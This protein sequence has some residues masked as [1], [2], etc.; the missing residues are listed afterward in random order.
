ME[1]GRYTRMFMKVMGNKLP[2]KWL[3][4]FLLGGVIAILVIVLAPRLRVNGAEMGGHSVHLPFILSSFSNSTVSE[5]IVF[6]S[7]QIPS[8]GSVYWNVPNGMAGVGPYSRFQVAAPGK[9]QI[10]QP[11]GVVRTLIDGE[12]PGPAPFD[13]IDVNAPDVSYDGTK[14]L[15]AGFSASA[16]EAADTMPN[17]TAGGW[18]IYSIHVDGTNLR[19]ITTTDLDYS[20]LDMS[21]FGAAA[22]LFTEYDDTDPV[23]LPDGRFVF[24]STRW[25]SIAQ[26]SGVRTTNLY[27]ANADGSEMRR[28]TSERN[29]AERPLID[30]LTGKIVYS[31]WWRNYRFATNNLNTLPHPDG[32]YAQR[33]GLTIQR[34][35]LGG[36]DNLWTNFWH[37]VAINPDGTDLAL[38]NGRFRGEHDNHYYGGAFT[39]D[40]Q[41]IANFFPMANMSEASGFGGL[42]LLTRGASLYTPLQ[43]ITDLRGN[44]VNSAPPSY[45]IYRGTYAAEPDVLAD[46]RIVFSRALNV[47]QDYGLYLMEADG[48]NPRRLY[49]A[50]GTAELRPRVIQQRPLPPIL[51]DTITQIPGPLPP[52]ANG[53]YDQD[54]TFIF[55]NFNVYFNAPVDSEIVN[56]PAIGSAD[57]IRFFIDH[58]RANRGS[59]PN[60][61]WPIL[62][63]ELPINP[64][65]SLIQ[66]NAP[67][68]VP[69]FEQIRAANGAVPLTNGPLG[70]NGAAHVTGMNFG[71][72]GE[73]VTC[74]GCHAGHSLIPVPASAEDALWTNLAPGAEIAVSSTRNPNYNRGVVDRQVLTGPIYHYWTS[75]FGQTEGQWVELTFPVPVVVRTVRLYNPRYGD[76]ANASLTVNGVT[77][78]LY[79]DPNGL[80]EV[81]S[82]SAGQLSV[83]GTDLPFDDI[84]AQVIR[85]EINNVTGTFYAAVAAGLAEIEVIARRAP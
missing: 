12:N 22:S 61:D 83:S 66:P 23:W 16:F 31:R 32:G 81:A 43:G 65:G 9:L 52:P 76:E 25:P 55:E 77:V 82:S 40:G 6:V 38:W 53:P 68:N 54:G 14:I 11:D 29:G 79:S 69:L 71:R 67:A 60:L 8:E 7:R 15:F 51:P 48:S 80:Q 85:I 2:L 50:P 59:F 5:A 56:A 47:S 24:A 10:L 30:P 33:D 1:N 49:N 19:Q 3:L 17:A 42:R 34:N 36:F 64:D 26:Y 21:Q 37:A 4:P 20:Q 27:V 62:L 45:G 70:I 35:H 75:A 13:L 74:V 46:G 41:L 58:Q 63:A 28:I 44:L 57:I 72:P 18:R 39:P 73:H 78:R 84:T